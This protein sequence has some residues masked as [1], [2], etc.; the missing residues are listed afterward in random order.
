MNMLDRVFLVFFARW[1]RKKGSCNLESAWFNASY[2]VST[3]IS[4]PLAAAALI[5]VALA[6]AVFG[7]GS[8]TDHKHTGQIIGVIAW[9]VAGFLLDRRF[10]KFLNDPP[11]LTHEESAS[12]KQLVFRFRA[13]SL[14]LFAVTC[15][16]D[17][18]LHRA[19]LLQGF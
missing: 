17:Y 2:R 15:L 1:R 7:T 6:Y 11:A 9:L 8:P 13:I 16:V 10:K 5:L 4:W 14:G 3:Y 18:L 12:D 19:Q